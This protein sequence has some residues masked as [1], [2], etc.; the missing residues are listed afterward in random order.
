MSQIKMV[1]LLQTLPLKKCQTKQC[2]LMLCLPSS[3][4]RSKPPS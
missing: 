3:T 4:P 1:S 2:H